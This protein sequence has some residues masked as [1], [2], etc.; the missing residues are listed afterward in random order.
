MLKYPAKG[1]VSCFL[2]MHK[3]ITSENTSPKT[4][5]IIKDI[6]VKL[7][8]NAINKKTSPKPKVFFNLSLNFEYMKTTKSKKNINK[9]FIITVVKNSSYAIFLNNRNPQQKPIIGNKNQ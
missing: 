3:W 5:S 9:K 7:K 1:T 8:D 2:A 6:L 4:K